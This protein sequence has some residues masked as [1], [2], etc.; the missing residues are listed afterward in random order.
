MREMTKQMKAFYLDE[1]CKHAN[2]L[3]EKVFKPAFIMAFVHGARHGREDLLN[4][5]NAKEILHAKKER[6]RIEF[7]KD[8]KGCACGECSDE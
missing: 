8:V 3:A 6:M 4:E 2:F 1:A 7:N 5:L